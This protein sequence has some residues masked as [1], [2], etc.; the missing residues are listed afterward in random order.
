MPRRLALALALLAACSAFAAEEIVPGVHLI[1]GRFTPGSQPDGN[2]VIVNAPDGLIVVDSGRHVA[3]TQ[4]IVDFAKSMKKPVKAIVNTHWHL[5]HVGGNVMLRREF[6]EARVYAS[7]ALSEALTGFLAN[8]RK[9]LTELI[10]NTAD[11]E[12]K[13]AFGVELALIE[14]GPKLAPDE[15]VTESSRRSL[16]GRSLEIGL[17]KHSVTAGDVWLF[18]PSTGV[19]VAG[20]LVTLPAPFLDTACPKKWEATLDRLAK[21]DFELLVPGHGPP[22]TRRQFATYRRAFSA[23]LACTGEK[24]ACIDGWMTGVAAL[25]PSEDANFTRMLMG[26]YADVLRREPGKDCG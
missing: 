23:L 7:G 8:Y 19:L 22:L 2:T 4:A 10:A 17:E 6:P 1:R 18:D 15:V 21:T 24:E 9:Q 12:Q 13:R 5:D 26:Y 14:A 25:I 3:H 16:A 20:D 11:A